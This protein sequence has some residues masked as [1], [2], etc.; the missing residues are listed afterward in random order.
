MCMCTLVVVFEGQGTVNET[1]YSE[2]KLYELN[3]L[4]RKVVY[5]ITVLFISDQQVGVGDLCVFICLSVR[6]TI[7]VAR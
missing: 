1:F 7:Y 4:L 3:S 5:D 2:S 6:H